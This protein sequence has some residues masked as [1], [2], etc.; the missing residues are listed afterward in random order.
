MPRAWFLNLG[1]STTTTTEADGDIRAI[2]RTEPALVVGCE[3]IGKGSLPSPGKTYVRIRDTSRP[4]RANLFAYVKGVD[5]AKFEWHWTDCAT[6]F[7]RNKYPGMH[8]PRS[9]LRF[10]FQGA[11][12]VVAHKPPAWKGAGPARAEHDDHLARIMNPDDGG[13][14]DHKRS[15]LLLWDSN[16]LEGAERLADQVDGRVVGKHIDQALVRQVEVVAHDYRTAINGH[17]FH[18]DHPWGAF[19]IQFDWRD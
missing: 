6:E 14:K 5:P 16:G 1:P 12:V 10:S 11:Q 9:I 4:G 13:E 2:L 8:W 3:A 19:F 18:T 17:T 7:P 15:R